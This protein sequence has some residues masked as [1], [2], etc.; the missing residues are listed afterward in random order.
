MM[1]RCTECK[2]FFRLKHNFVVGEGFEESHCCL[3]LVPDEGAFVL[4]VREDD[5]C[6]CFQRKKVEE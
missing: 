2:H 5:F 3:L 1:E 6:E 4:E